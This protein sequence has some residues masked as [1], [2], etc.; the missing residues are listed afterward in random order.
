MDCNPLARGHVLSP[1]KRFHAEAAPLRHRAR[2][3]VDAFDY[4]AAPLLVGYAII[5]LA[6]GAFSSFLPNET[7]NIGLEDITMHADFV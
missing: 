6:L 7:A 2:S 5:Q 3:L 1:R 4:A